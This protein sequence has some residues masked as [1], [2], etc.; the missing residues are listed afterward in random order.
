MIAARGAAYNFTR[1]PAKSSPDLL[2]HQTFERSKGSL[3]ISGIR[4][5]GD[6]SASFTDDKTGIADYESRDKRMNVVFERAANLE[7]RSVD[8]IHLYIYRPRK[9]RHES[10]WD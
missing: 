9:C 6:I 1:A 10:P 5:A 8:P 4:H 2:A 7:A 3:T